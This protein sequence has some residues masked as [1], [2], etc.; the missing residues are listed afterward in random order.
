MKLKLQLIHNDITLI[1][2]CVKIKKKVYMYIVFSHKLWYMLL[3]VDF[4]FLF[5][6]CRILGGACRSYL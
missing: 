4:V 2:D 6:I 3:G 1:L 5:R